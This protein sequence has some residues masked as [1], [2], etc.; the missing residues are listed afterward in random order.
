VDITGTVIQ[1]R[2]GARG[3]SVLLAVQTG[4]GFHAA[5]YPMCTGGA[6]PGVKRLQREADQSPPVGIKVRNDCSSTFTALTGMTLL[7][8]GVEQALSVGLLP[9]IHLSPTVL[10]CRCIHFYVFFF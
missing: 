9:F 7:L 6:F 2:A 5:F 3:F 10:Q 4:S 1:L 8:P